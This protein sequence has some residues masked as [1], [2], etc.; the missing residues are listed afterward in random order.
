MWPH[1]FIITD[2]LSKSHLTRS[3]LVRTCWLPK[4]SMVVNSRGNSPAQVQVPAAHLLKEREPG[5]PT[6]LPRLQFLANP[7]VHDPLYHHPPPSLDP[8]PP[9]LF[10]LRRGE[11]FWSLL[12]SSPPL[13]LHVST[14]SSTSVWCAFI[15]PSHLF[16]S[17]PLLEFWQF[18]PKFPTTFLIKTL[19]THTNSTYTVKHSNLYSEEP[20][21]ISFF[22][23]KTFDAINKN[24]AQE[25][26]ALL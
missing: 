22:L 14:H 5:G 4:A 11:P 12:F 1:I 23:N 2:L 16:V 6:C 15:S 20:M 13:S 7:R 18:K 17:Q 26:R 9:L 21:V 19:P 10:F 25:V 24:Q 3:A 8:T